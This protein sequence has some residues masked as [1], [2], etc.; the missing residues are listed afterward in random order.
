[1]SNYE[2]LFYNGWMDTPAYYLV[3]DVEGETPEQALAV[4]LDQVIE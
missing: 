1:M 4:N 2:V 3:S